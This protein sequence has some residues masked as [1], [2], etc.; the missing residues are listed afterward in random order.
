MPPE[1]A[2]IPCVALIVYLFWRELREADIEKISWVP[3]V[4]MFIAAS[5][6]PSRWVS[7]AAP[8]SGDGTDGSPFDRTIF[9]SLIILGVIVLLRRKIAWGE[10]F[11]QNKWLVLYFGYCLFSIFWADEQF[12]LFKRWF[13]DLGNPI[14]AL[15]LLTERRPYDALATT[16]RRISYVFMPL[17]VLFIK[18]YP[19]LG[20]IHALSGAPTYTGAA[21]QKNTLGLTC[22]II[23]FC[24]LWSY[25][26]RRDEIPSLRHRYHL[27]VMAM[28]A[29]LFW[30]ANSQTAFLC[31]LIGVAILLLSTRPAV[32]R[33]PGRLVG[34]VAACALIYVVADSTI[35]LKEQIFVFLGRDSTLTNRTTIWDAVNSVG[36]NPVVGVGFQSFWQGQR[37]QAVNE[38]LGPNTSLNQAHNGYLEQYVNLGY[39]GIAF[40]VVIALMSLI[41]IRR[42]FA[43]NYAAATLR[44]AFV[45]LALLYNYTE[46]SFYGINNIWLLFLMVGMNPPRAANVPAVAHERARAVDWRRRRAA[47]QPAFARGRR[48]GRSY[49]G[50]H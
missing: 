48:V 12:V 37:R 10:L 50:A 38:A 27:L 31:L 5:R 9:L 6:F 4:W 13:K 36:T 40:I 32:A 34:V 19:H 8:G 49:S 2:A 15:I 47:P 23:T 21:D 30:M 16:F 11:T 29:W 3:F 43:M 33:R 14:M 1:L 42:D 24:Y 44:F 17:S 20:R 41:R 46:A 39:V 45:V 35:G 7:L 25:L 22:L 18:Y 26:H 28:T